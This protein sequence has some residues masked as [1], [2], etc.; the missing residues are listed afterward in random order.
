MEYTENEVTLGQLF[1]VVRKSGKEKNI[2]R[3]M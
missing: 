1:K 2:G 3:S